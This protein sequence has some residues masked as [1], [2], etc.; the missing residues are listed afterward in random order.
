MVDRLPARRTPAR[1]F[2]P[3]ALAA[4]IASTLFVVAHALSTNNATAPPV[5]HSS[6]HA[7]ASH[8]AQPASRH[9]GPSTYVIRSGDT[10][11]SIAGRFGVTVGVIELLN[12]GLNA[13][14]LQVGQRVRLRR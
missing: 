6:H 4:T 11:G 5:T 10:L 12:P 13:N 1:L 7:G 3:L 9:R 8:A 14:A 2:V